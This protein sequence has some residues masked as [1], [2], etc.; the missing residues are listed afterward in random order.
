[1]FEY[2]DCQFTTATEIFKF[3]DKYLVDLKSYDPCI[4]IAAEYFL[5]AM[6]GFSS[7]CDMIS[8]IKKIYL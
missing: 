7:K 3:Y 8:L 6:T 2:F 5:F 1:M 4:Q